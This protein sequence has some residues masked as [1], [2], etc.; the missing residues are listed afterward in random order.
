MAKVKTVEEILREAVDSLLER[1]DASQKEV[2]D[3]VKQLTGFAR[4]TRDNVEKERRA[5]LKLAEKT[6][7]QANKQEL[8]GM[9][10]DIQRAIKNI[11]N[12]RDGRDGLDGK[13]PDPEEVARIAATL[14][15]FPEV[16]DNSEDIQD[17][18]E[19]V[20]TLEE[21]DKKYRKAG[22]FGGTA[23]PFSAANSPKHQAFSMNGA[24]TSVTL[25]DGVAAEGTAVF[26]RYQGQLLDHGNQYTVNGNTINL[27]FTP[28]NGTTISVTYW[29]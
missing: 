23:Q 28:A 6:L 5:V 27:T 2:R 12:G 9:K 15:P 8:A 25:S 29:P 21:Q 1:I 13:D 18:Q 4:E 11:K 26:V 22:I 7:K 24:T 14:V 10:E 3:V 19:R 17:L 16:V 20:E